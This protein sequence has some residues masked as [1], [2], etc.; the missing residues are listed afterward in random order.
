MSTGVHVRVDPQRNRRA[1][2]HLRGN[3][4]QAFELIGGFDVEAVHAHFQG[5]AHVLA[6]LAD[7]GEH[8]AV[9]TATGCQDAF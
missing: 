1:N 6:G 3:H 4:L 2:A 7:T 8:H 5:A 9:G